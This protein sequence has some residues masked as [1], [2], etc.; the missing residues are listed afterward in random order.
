MVFLL[1][2]KIS[3]RVNFH[4]EEKIKNSTFENKMSFLS[5]ERSPLDDR[6]GFIIETSVDDF[7]EKMKNEFKKE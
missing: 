1:V 3:D 7:D 4:F 2:E 6:N 5:L